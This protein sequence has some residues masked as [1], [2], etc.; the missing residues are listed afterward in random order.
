MP[1][2][3]DKI[4]L[5]KGAEM[6]KAGSRIIEV[7][8]GYAVQKVSLAGVSI[9]PTMSLQKA[10]SLLAAAQHEEAEREPG[11]WAAEGMEEEKFVG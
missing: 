3:Q 9:S 7:S 11:G 1:S 2:V 10:K 6:L 5:R 8:G 4:R